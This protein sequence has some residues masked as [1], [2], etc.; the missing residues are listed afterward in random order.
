MRT[1]KSGGGGW[2]PD[3]D[4]SIALAQA[5]HYEAE[6]RILMRAS[7][8]EALVRRSRCSDAAPG[9]PLTSRILARFRSAFHWLATARSVGTSRPSIEG[10]PI[11]HPAVEEETSH[12]R[13]Q[14]QACR[15][16]SRITANFA[17]RNP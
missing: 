9:E 2:L 11:S 15:S 1:G 12:I 17:R 6:H 8:D 16:A 5:M 13:L 4:L 3:I 7:S 14:E 10:Y